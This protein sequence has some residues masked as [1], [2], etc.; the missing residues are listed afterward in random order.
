M[1]LCNDP[2]EFGLV[3]RVFHWGMMALVIAMLALGTQINVLEPGLARGVH[4]AFYAL[5][6][7]SP[8]TGWAGSSATGIDVMI[9]G[10][11]DGADAGRGLGSDR[12]TVFRRAWRADQTAD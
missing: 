11:W 10:R 4:W 2:D 8:L 9:A 1:G 6:V 12:E 7:A 5:L 3:T